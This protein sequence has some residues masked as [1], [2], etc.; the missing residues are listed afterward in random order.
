MHG[1]SHVRSHVFCTDAFWDSTDALLGVPCA[2][3]LDQAIPP[4]LV[5]HNLYANT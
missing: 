1:Y 4:F 5:H 2:H 3:H